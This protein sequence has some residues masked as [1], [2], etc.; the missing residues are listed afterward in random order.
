MALSKPRATK[1]RV[2]WLERTIGTIR[3]GSWLHPHPNDPLQAQCDTCNK[4]IQLGSSGFSAIVHHA[5]GAKHTQA[6]QETADK[7]SRRIDTFFSRG[8]IDESKNDNKKTQE[9]EKVMR[10]ELRYAIHL[11]EHKIAFVSADH[12]SMFKEMFSD[13]KVASSFQCKRTKVT[14][15]INDAIAPEVRNVIIQDLNSGC[16]GFSLS[17][18]ESNDRARKFLAINLSFVSV[19]RKKL[20]VLPIKCI[21]LADGKAVTL[22]DAVVE[23]LLELKLEMKNCVSIMSDGPSVMIGRHNGFHKLM[24]D[25]APHLLNIPTCSL[26]HVANAVCKACDKLGQRSERFCDGVYSY[27]NYTSR[28]TLFKDV[29]SLLEVQSHRLLRRVETRWLQILPV[30]NRVLE[31]LPALKKYFLDVLPQQKPDELRNERVVELRASLREIALELDLC[32]LQ[33]ILPTLD[34]FEK[35]YQRDEPQIHSLHMDIR[36]MYK[37]VLVL[38]LKS[39]YVDENARRL[40]TMSFD[41]T[42]WLSEDELFVGNKARDVLQLASQREKQEFFVRVKSFYGCLANSL[43]ETLPLSDPILRN[44]R[45][46]APDFRVTEDYASGIAKS[47][48]WS[49]ADCDKLCT[50]WR[51]IKIDSQIKRLQSEVAEHKMS[52]TDFWCHVADLNKYPTLAKLSLYSLTVPCNNAATERVFS[53][54]SDLL[55]KKRN[56]LGEVSIDS[57]LLIDFYLKQAGVTCTDFDISDSLI[58]AG[59]SARASAVKRQQELKAEQELAEKE[60][61][62][63]RQIADQV[64]HEMSQSKRHKKIVDKEKAI[65]QAKVGN[66]ERMKEADEMLKAYQQKVKALVLEREE[67]DRKEQKNQKSK[68]SSERK[69]V[70]QAIANAVSGTSSG[71]EH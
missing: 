22:R 67:I 34:Q 7:A 51:L 55:T 31:Q 6:M 3:V 4:V 64:E 60:A 19:K 21:E 2:E 18:D 8:N 52:V 69:L 61:A 9:Q 24:R 12:S 35:A 13:S 71:M 39:S 48:Q 38:F 65:V 68:A 11:V 40:S 50:D 20:M 28:W 5:Q 49:S 26:H 44:L 37:S 45:F 53:S 1:F 54:L 30:V 16:G 36:E 58:S 17:V 15:L 47:L 41:R 25:V 62:R 70:D 32:F 33:A 46:L 57:C 59:F 29:Q 63:K 14:Y 23:T 66:T 56:S 42:H 43:Q 27:F 10:A